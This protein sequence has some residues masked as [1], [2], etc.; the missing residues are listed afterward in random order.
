MIRADQALRLAPL[1]RGPDDLQPTLPGLTR[2]D[3]VP[4]PDAFVKPKPRFAG[5]SGLVTSLADYAAL[6]NNLL[7]GK[8]LKPSTLVEMMRDQVPAKY[9]VIVSGSE[10]YREIG[11]GL[12]GAV[13]R[14]TSSLQPNSPTDEFQWGGLGG[15]HWC[16]SQ[17]TGIAI[18]LMTQRYFGFWNPF[19]F[20][21]KQKVYEACG[22]GA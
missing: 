10:P 9:C 18:V 4:W 20:E 14:R 15:T 19:W 12:G 6:L 16:M 5:T 11:F 1:Y 21:Y 7:G 17:S 13:T 2:M 8:F 3:N 22:V